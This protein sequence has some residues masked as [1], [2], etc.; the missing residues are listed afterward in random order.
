MEAGALNA[1]NARVRGRGKRTLRRHCSKGTG[2]KEHGAAGSCKCGGR[3]SREHAPVRKSKG[4]G[5]RAERR[6]LTV[7]NAGAASLH[8]Q[9]QGIMTRFLHGSGRGGVEGALR[10]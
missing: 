5:G 9:L 7:C 4:A 2:C 10:V 3:R 8:G 6:R 1:H